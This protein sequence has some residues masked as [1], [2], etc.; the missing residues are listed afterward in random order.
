MIMT[1]NIDK[2]LLIILLNIKKRIIKKMKQHEK[3][4]FNTHMNMLKNKDKIT[5]S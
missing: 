2:K 3:N 1:K 4:K 5:K